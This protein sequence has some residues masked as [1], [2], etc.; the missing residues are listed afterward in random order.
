MEF[1]KVAVIGA[2]NIGSGG[3]TDLVLHNIHTVLVDINPDQLDWAR[4]EIIKNIRFAPMLAK[5]IP[6][7][8]NEEA[9]K[10][11]TFTLDLSD[12][13]SCQFVA[14]NVTEDWATQE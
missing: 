11:I 6:K 9:L 12:A 13:A 8:N 2:G 10:R 7:V 1:N 4:D 14:E 3:A 5:N